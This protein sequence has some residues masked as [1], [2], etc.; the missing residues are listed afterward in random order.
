MLENIDG[1]LSLSIA[2][3]IL[4]ASVAGGCVSIVLFLVFG[5]VKVWAD[6]RIW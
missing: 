1:G 3:G 4:I 2:P 5:A 6:K